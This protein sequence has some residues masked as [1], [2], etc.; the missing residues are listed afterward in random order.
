M[1]DLVGV[2][3]TI[4]PLVPPTCSPEVVRQACWTKGSLCPCFPGS[5]ERQTRRTS[6]EHGKPLSL[7]AHNQALTKAKLVFAVERANPSLLLISGRSMRRTAVHLFESKGIAPSFGMKFTGHK[8]VEVYM[9]YATL[10]SMRD[11]HK[12]AETAFGLIAFVAD[13]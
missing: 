6:N 5:P 1:L 12:V 7:Q 10:P 13:E 4:R 8:S 9:Q 11:L 3:G 2:S